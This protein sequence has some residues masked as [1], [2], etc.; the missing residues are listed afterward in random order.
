MTL[1]QTTPLPYFNT[2]ATRRELQTQILRPVV[3]SLSS[4]ELRNMTMLHP[5]I[6][7]LVDLFPEKA[8]DWGE[9]GMSY[10]KY[11]TAAFIERHIDKPWCWKELSRQPTSIPIEF[12]QAHREKPWDYQALSHNKNVPT[13]FIRDTMDKPWRFETL[14]YHPNLTF[15][16]VFSHLDKAWWWYELSRRRD[17]TWK[18]IE[19][20]PDAPWDWSAL[21]NNPAI[22]WDILLA[23]PEKP[24]D[25]TQ[26]S[27]SSKATRER[28]L[29]HPDLPWNM[30][31][32]LSYNMAALQPT[33]E[34]TIRYAQEI[35]AVRR[36]WRAWF[37]ANTNPAFAVCRHRLLCEMNEMNDINATSA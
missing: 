35:F 11:I 16:I 6:E 2:M 34:E 17:I 7:M 31:A 4:N 1:K 21:S 37:R 13:S 15:D 3:D 32:L 23:H 12:I 9:N 36:I 28:I 24:W 5:Q 30:H 19:E 18:V 29:S 20:H 14:S 10:N 25:W 22:S 26:V 33:D 8:W 27:C